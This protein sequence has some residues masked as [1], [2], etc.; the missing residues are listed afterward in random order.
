MRFTL[1]HTSLPDL[2]VAERHPLND[3]RGYLERVFCQEDLADVLQGKTIAQIN[4]TLTTTT[5]IVRGMHF[6]FPPHAEVKFVSCLKGEVFDVA[7]DLRK[8]SPTFLRWHAE[9]LS[10]ANRKTLIV[11]QGFAHGFQTLAENCEL[12]YLHTAAYAKAAEGALNALDPG[13]AI[14]WPLPIAELSAR[15][16]GHP[17]LDAA[18]KGIIP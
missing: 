18:F 13:L 1:S 6:Q 15:D 7:V 12:L 5:G 3:G 2:M 17:M 10:E 14:A 8:S 16:R 9:I 4:R 11:P